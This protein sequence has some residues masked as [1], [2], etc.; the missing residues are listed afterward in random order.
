M[1]IVRAGIVWTNRTLNGREKGEW[2]PSFQA[3]PGQLP[4]FQFRSVDDSIGQIC[5]PVDSKATDPTF[6][7]CCRHFRILNVVIKFIKFCNA[8]PVQIQSTA[9]TAF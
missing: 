9:A 2:G 1:R 6:K 5:F 8:E 3:L 4:S 7:P